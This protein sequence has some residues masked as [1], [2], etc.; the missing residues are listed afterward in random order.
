LKGRSKEKKY[1]EEERDFFSRQKSIILL[2]G[3]QALPAL[4]SGNGIIIVKT[5]GRLDNRN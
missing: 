2:E 5:F 1:W 4:P 3:S